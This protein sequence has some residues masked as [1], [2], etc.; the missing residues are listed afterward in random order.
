MSPEPA[1]NLV[2]LA[3]LAGWAVLGIVMTFGALF[4]PAEAPGVGVFWL[5]CV[6]FAVVT[7]V[8]VARTT[9][10]LGALGMHGLVLLILALLPRMFPLSLLRA[11][12]DILGRG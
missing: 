2:H 5:W 11:G 7:T 3:L 4:H 6:G 12:L 9:S 8:L 1:R 10:P